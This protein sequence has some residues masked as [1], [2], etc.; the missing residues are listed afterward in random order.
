MTLLLL[1]ASILT[2]SEQGASLVRLELTYPLGSSPS[3][4]TKGWS[5][6]AKA[7]GP[8]GVELSQSVRWSGTG[9]FTPSTGP[10]S[11]PT[12]AKPGLN[13]IVLSLAFKGK[14]IT[15]TF[16]VSAVD[17]SGY[18]HVG[19]IASCSADSH[20]CP[21][22][23]HAVTGPV[24]Q[25]SPDVLV[26]G[27]PAARVGD[28]G[29][30]ASCCGTNTFTIVEGDPKVL[31][32]GRR[33]AKI[34]ARTKHCGGDGRLI[35]PDTRTKPVAK[36]WNLVRTDVFPKSMPE[37]SQAVQY[38]LRIT[39]SSALASWIRSDIPTI[40]TS[41]RVMWTDI[42]GRL[43][44]GERVSVTFIP[45]DAGSSA[46]AQG[47]LACGFLVLFADRKSAPWQARGQSPLTYAELGTPM[48]TR[49]DSFAVPPGK[50]GNVL[51][52]QI[53]VNSAIVSQCGINFVYEFKA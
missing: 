24:A 25:G 48:A 52:V 6:G 15:R 17:P 31:I 45:Q 28:G 12:F 2:V 14:R 49:T 33:A 22:C 43:V 51:I 19:T 38:Q 23:P 53:G 40:R 18:A 35:P 41:L 44:P 27:K 32:K 26:D 9:T 10:S 5:F 20:G 1:L 21:S 34:G 7:I 47:F 36:G 29:A 4:F 46:N 3:V 30:H 16:S 13:K 37:S 11:K 42:P 50:V 8:R 39:N